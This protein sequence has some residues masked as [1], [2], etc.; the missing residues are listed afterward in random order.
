MKILARQLA[1]DMYNCK[2]EKLASAE[3]LS[4]DL[5]T[6]LIQVGLTPLPHEIRD[7]EENH[8]VI[9]FPLKEGHLT[10]HVYT[11]LRYSAVDLFICDH[12]GLSEKVVWALRKVI[13]PEEI[14]MTYLC[15]GDFGTVSD[16]KPHTKVKMAA[17]RR[18]QHTGVKVIRLLPG[19]NF[20]KKLRRKK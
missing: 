1:I 20:M 3:L 8:F 12:G 5:N 13:K 4:V 18:I 16:M 7:F 15:R 9:F 11:A 10:I 2:P 14:K 6:A 19:R 17:L